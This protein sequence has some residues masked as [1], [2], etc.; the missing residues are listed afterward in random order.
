MISLMRIAVFLLVLANL[1][2]FVWARG[3]LGTSGT[4]DTRRVEQQLLADQLRIV[5]RGQPPPPTPGKEAAE[6]S[7]APSSSVGCQSWNGLASGEADQVERLL[8][9]KRFAAF[10]ATRRALSENTGYWVYVPP[11][12]SREEVRQKTDQLQQLG[13]D[14]FFIVQASGPQPSGDFARHLPHRGRRPRGTRG[15][16][17]QRGAVGSHESADRKTGIGG[18]RNSWPRIAG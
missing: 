2:F 11:L 1:L 15:L 5:S 8:T 17:G 6:R 12:A 18:D 10:Q 13:V 9:E 7:A 4:P 3:Y 16:A 14:D